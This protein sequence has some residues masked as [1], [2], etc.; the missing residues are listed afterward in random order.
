GPDHNVYGVSIPGAPAVVIGFNSD[1][2]WGVTNGATDVRDWYKLTLKEDLSAYE[3]DGEWVSVDKRVET[4][5]V[6]HAETF[7]DTVYL[8]QYGPIVSDA[9]FTAVPEFQHMALRWGLHTPSNEYRA[10]YGLN[11]AQNYD[12]FKASIQHFKSPVQNFTYAD[13]E[14]HIALHHQGLVYQ[15]GVGEGTFVL[16][17]AESA[18]LPQELPQDQLPFQLDPVQGFVANANNNPFTVSDS[19]YVGGYWSEL[20]AATLRQNLSGLEAS[21]VTDMQA[22][23][24]DNTNAFA[25]RAL[26]FLL[27]QLE[28]STGEAYAALKDW[29]GR[30]NASSQA[31]VYFDAWWDLIQYYAWDELF[32]LPHFFRTPDDVVQ[33][34]LMQQQPNHP[35]FDRLETEEVETAQEVIRKA[36]EVLLSET[37]PD[38]WGAENSVRFSHFTELEALG[39][40][41]FNPQGHPDA[42]NALSENWGPTWR[43]VVEMTDEPQGVGLVAGGTTG[44]PV[45]P[46]YD[47][48]LEDWQAGRY[49][50]LQRYPDAQ[51][52]QDAASAVWTSENP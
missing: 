48:A 51:A 12:Q 3:V 35:L 11:R 10:L 18:E 29:D 20:R 4:F 7:T 34:T 5:R 39:R 33:L 27:S 28:T 41:G 23:Q 13:T 40:S 50:P 30:Y 31:A 47:Q 45:S 6:R 42:L 14:G 16:D 2:A 22:L 52:A 46:Q 19:T 25:V 8:T 44:N 26:P 17:G 38:S 1:L 37:L 43:M 9:Q 21:T 15:R 36:W 49:F 32:R 24:L